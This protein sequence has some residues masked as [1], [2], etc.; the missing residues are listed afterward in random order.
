MKK[1]ILPLDGKKVF[2]QKDTGFE[3]QKSENKRNCI[4]K[5]VCALATQ[6]LAWLRTL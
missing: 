6:E 4:S 3:Q 5:Q 1:N 2:F